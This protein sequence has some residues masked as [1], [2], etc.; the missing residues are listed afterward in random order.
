MQLRYWP[1]DCPS[2][3]SSSSK[4]SS[5]PRPLSHWIIIA[6]LPYHPASVLSFCPPAADFIDSIPPFNRS[7]TVILPPIDRPAHLTWP[8]MPVFHTKTIESILEPVAQQV[9][10]FVLIYKFLIITDFIPH[11]CVPTLLFSSAIHPSFICIAIHF[12]F[13]IFLH[14]LSICHLNSVFFYGSK[15]T[16]THFPLFLPIID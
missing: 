15:H 4:W 11:C 1:I 7:V 9:S 3:S 2:S 8:T 16:H 12:P 10:S 13:C 6:P 5:A 14:A